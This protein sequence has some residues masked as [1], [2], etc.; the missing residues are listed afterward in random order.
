MATQEGDV[1][2]ELVLGIGFASTLSG[3]QT[4][5][6]TSPALCWRIRC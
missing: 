1:P 5:A 6:A 4:I 2:C 3:S